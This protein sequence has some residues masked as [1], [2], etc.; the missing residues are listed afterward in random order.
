MFLNLKFDGKKQDIEK[1]ELLV[2][3]QGNKVYNIPKARK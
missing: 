3:A 1:N 2:E